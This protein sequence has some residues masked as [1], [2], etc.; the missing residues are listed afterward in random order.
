MERVLKGFFPL[1]ASFCAQSVSK[2]SGASGANVEVLS[3]YGVESIERN[4]L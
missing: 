2:G 1:L 3:C 4:R